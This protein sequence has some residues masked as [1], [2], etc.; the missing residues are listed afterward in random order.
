MPMTRIALR[1]GKPA[2][3]RQTLMAQV[4]E[5]MRD[6]FDVPE[7]DLFMMLTEHDEAQIAFGRTYM[8]IERSDDVILIQITASNTRTV[9]KKRALYRRIAERLVGSLGIRP[10]DV[11]VNLVE[12]S[13]EN[14]SFGNGE[15]QLAPE[16]FSPAH[17]WRRS[18]GRRAPVTGSELRSG[19]F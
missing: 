11:F 17:W 4:Y 8:D 7:D 9:E 1:R 15:A 14:W 13:K 3:Y 5:A 12:V 6:T 10:Q 2:A 19:V 16:P 18:R